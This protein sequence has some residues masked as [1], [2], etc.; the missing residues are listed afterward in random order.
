MKK[1]L[2]AFKLWSYIAGMMS[3]IIFA[4]V[5]LF[6]DI[7]QYTNYY[8]YMKEIF[9]VIFISVIVISFFVV[10]HYFEL[11]NINV[12]AKNKITKYFKIYFGILWRAILILSPIIGFI[13]YKY[14]GS[15]TSRIITIIIEIIAGLP[16]IWWFLHSK[17]IKIEK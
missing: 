8:F 15:I 16:A 6:M 7:M 17:E 12:K 4:S 11:F 13:A 3:L 1:F 14:H 10:N 2:L 5:I 9:V